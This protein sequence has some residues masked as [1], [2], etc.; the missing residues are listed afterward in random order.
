MNF[1][2]IQKGMQQYRRVKAPEFQRKKKQQDAWHG[3]NGGSSS[4]SRAYHAHGA[5]YRVILVVLV[6][7]LLRPVRRTA[8]CSR[9]LD[10]GHGCTVHAQR[11]Q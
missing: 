7:A 1:H 6:Y 10:A 8:T 3:T 9:P 4:A 2:E 11:D 5:A